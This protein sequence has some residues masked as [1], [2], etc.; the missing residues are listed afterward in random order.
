MAEPISSQ[1][2]EEGMSWRLVVPVFTVVLWG[3]FNV[4]G[5]YSMRWDLLEHCHALEMGKPRPLFYS[6]MAYG[7]VY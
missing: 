6:A 7:Y 1:A 4:T 2:I 5:A 3:I